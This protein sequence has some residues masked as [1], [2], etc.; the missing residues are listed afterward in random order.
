MFNYNYNPP[1][2]LIQFTISLKSNTLHSTSTPY[3]FREAY[4][5]VRLGSA[6]EYQSCPSQSKS[7]DC[8]KL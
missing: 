7:I 2:F 5:E 1:S 8:N 4:D 6:K 3:H